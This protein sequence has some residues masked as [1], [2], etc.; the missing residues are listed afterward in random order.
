[1]G[2]KM[3]IIKEDW[4]ED[5][6]GTHSSIPNKSMTSKTKVF[7]F[8]SRLISNQSRKRILTQIQICWIILVLKKI[9]SSR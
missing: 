4:E 3:E 9:L 7:Y 1:M 6:D 8:N 2:G 5:D